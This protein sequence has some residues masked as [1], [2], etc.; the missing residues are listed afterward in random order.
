VLLRL[1][2]VTAMNQA[3][4][5][6]GKRAVKNNDTTARRADGQHWL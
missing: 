6:I 1:F 3:W 2:G 5:Q 4:T